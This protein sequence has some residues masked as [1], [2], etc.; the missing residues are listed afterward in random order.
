M[1]PANVSFPPSP[2][3]PVVAAVIF[4]VVV[5]VLELGFPAVPPTASAAVASV[6]AIVLGGL[7]HHVIA[8]LRRRRVER[9]AA[10]AAE[11]AARLERIRVLTGR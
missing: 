11:E 4:A 7:T 1:N 2:T 9:L 6:P 8:V 10:E 5:T 3:G